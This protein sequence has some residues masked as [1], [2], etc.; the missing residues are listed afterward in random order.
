MIYQRIQ[1]MALRSRIL[2]SSQSLVKGSGYATATASSSS[3]AVT[4]SSLT[5]LETRWC[6]LPEA[7]QGAIADKLAL[8]QKGDWKKLT[9]E[10]KRAGNV[11]F[12]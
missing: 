6:K 8:L 10:E 7:E 9:L 3:P 1:T 2:K 12:Y 5:G 4:G 11:L